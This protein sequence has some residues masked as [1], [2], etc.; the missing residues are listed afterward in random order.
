MRDHRVTAAFATLMFAACSADSSVEPAVD[1]GSGSGT[2]ADE[3]VLAPPPGAD[4]TAARVEAAALAQFAAD[5]AIDATEFDVTFEAGTMTVRSTTTSPEAWHRAEALAGQL[6]EVASVTM[7]TAAPEGEPGELPEGL[8][9][10]ADTFD[11]ATAFGTPPETPIELPSADGEGSGEGDGL[12]AAA[13]GDRP[14]TYVVGP[15]DSLSIIAQRTMGDGMAWPQL[16]EFNR[17]VIGP[18]PG[19]LRQGMELRIPQD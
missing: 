16:Y 3:E 4:R 14:R 19:A 18:D 10:V 9:R 1:D 17:N 2:S 11:T 6:E 12:A 8:H 5:P 13:S 15:G 7:G